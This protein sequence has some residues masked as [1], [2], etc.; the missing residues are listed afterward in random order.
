MILDPHVIGRLQYKE[1]KLGQ[2]QA[3]LGPRAILY[4]TER[5]DLRDDGVSDLIF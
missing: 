3:I 2:T 4:F 5:G 1:G